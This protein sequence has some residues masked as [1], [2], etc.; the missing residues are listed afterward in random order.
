MI[1]KRTVRSTIQ[2]VLSNVLRDAG[3]EVPEFS[4]EALLAGTIQLDSL[5]FAVV[6]VNLERE[7]GVDPFRKSTQR[8]RTFGELVNLYEE[9]VAS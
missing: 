6:I 2:S 7:F 3:R 8:I 1:D 4:D 9:H 5:D